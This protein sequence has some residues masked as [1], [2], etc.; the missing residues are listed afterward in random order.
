MLVSIAQ[1]SAKLFQLLTTAVTSP[2]GCRMP[3]QRIKKLL[4]RETCGGGTNLTDIDDRRRG[5]EGCSGCCGADISAVQLIVGVVQ[6]F[7]YYI[8][9]SM[10]F[11]AFFYTPPKIPAKRVF[12][13]LTISQ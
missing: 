3:K 13:V 2:I 8:L 1:I 7:Y 5:G 12:L 10:E 9:Y 11:N 4:S 6:N